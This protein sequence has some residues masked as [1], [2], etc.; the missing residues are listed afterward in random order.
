MGEVMSIDWNSVR[1]EVVGHLQALLRIDT[2]NPPG[3][4]TAAAAYLADVAR[5]AGIPHELVGGVPGRDNFVA[6]LRANGGSGG[7]TVGRPVILLG[8]TD[9]VGV[10]RE[11]WTRDPFGGDVADGYVW[12]RGA[13]DMKNQVAANLMVMLLLKRQGVALGRDVIMAATADEE[14]G[15]ALGAHWLWRNRRDLIDAEYGLNEAGGDLVEI[16]GRRFY[17]VQT[18]EK[19]KARMR[20]VARAAPGHASVPLDDTAMYRLGKALVTLHEF[21]PPT[22]VTGPVARMLRALGPAYGL[23]DARVEELIQRPTW[24]AL[25]SLPMDAARRNDLRATTHNTA[26]PTVLGGGHRINVIPSEVWVDVDGRVL[27]GQDPAAWVRQVQEAVGDR[28]EVQLTEGEPG[29]EADPAS[30]FFDAIAATM[31]AEDPGSRLLPYLVSGGTD[32]RALP[33]VKVYGFMPA[34][35]D[36]DVLNLAHGHDE[37]THVDDLLFATR[38]LYGVVTRFCA[39]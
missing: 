24:D 11:R 20:I 5:A 21:A 37:R 31:E 25:A 12:G 17:T 16:D 27:P 2:V 35:A 9:V 18:G 36:T 32:A 3:N 10:E 33:G 4:E 7:S 26:V 13:V 28:V 34:R 30:P 14:A 39:L 15:S 22:I 23:T 6:R 38:C 19:G 29:I 8:H 1:D